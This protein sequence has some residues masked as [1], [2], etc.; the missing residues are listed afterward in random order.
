M[1]ISISGAMGGPTAATS[2]GTGRPAGPNSG[3]PSD[4]GGDSPIQDLVKL[5]EELLVPAAKVAGS[6]A[7]SALKGLLSSFAK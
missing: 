2:M 7:G 6:V 4:E 1:A 5:S 3:G